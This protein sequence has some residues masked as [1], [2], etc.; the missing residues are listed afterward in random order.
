MAAAANILAIHS[1]AEHHYCVL[2]TSVCVYEDA[3]R[4]CAGGQG[5][6]YR[7]DLLLSEV[8]WDW[9]SKQEHLFRGYRYT[10]LL[11]YLLPPL[12]LLLLPRDNSI[13][14]DIIRVLRFCGSRTQDANLGLRKLHYRKPNASHLLLH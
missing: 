14:P 6:M 4:Y 2:L 8:S 7:L 1:K 13:H 12:L 11:S 9:L 10:H 3:E 5:C